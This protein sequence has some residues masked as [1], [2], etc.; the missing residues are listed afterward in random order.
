MESNDSVLSFLSL[1][2]LN[3][4]ADSKDEEI[5]TPPKRSFLGTYFANPRCMKLPFGTL[6]ILPIFAILFRLI[7]FFC[8]VRNECMV[9]IST[10]TMS[11]LCFFSPN[12]NILLQ[13]SFTTDWGKRCILFI[14]EAAFHSFTGFRPL[15]LPLQF[16]G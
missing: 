7:F 4:A 8:R 2:F 9:V 11:V 16:P 5:K 14:P 12:T 15:K 10:K 6:S 1:R 13:F 3:V